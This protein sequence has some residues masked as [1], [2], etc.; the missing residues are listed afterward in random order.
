MTD[1]PR[2]LKMEG[3]TLEVELATAQ[4]RIKELEG[5]LLEMGLRRCTN[6]GTH[7]MFGYCKAVHGT[8]PEYFGCTLWSPKE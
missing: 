4:A 5:Y 7:D 8:P 1:E 3:A 2:M 6:C